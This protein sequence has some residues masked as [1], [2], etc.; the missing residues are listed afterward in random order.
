MPKTE[1]IKPVEVLE[2]D[3]PGSGRALVA[4]MIYTAHDGKKRSALS[5]QRAVR[6][7]MEKALKRRG[8][9]PEMGKKDSSSCSESDIVRR[10]ISV[11]VPA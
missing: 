8:W 4:F 5:D 3:A 11:V 9:R 2:F 1:I 7:V 6:E 10:T